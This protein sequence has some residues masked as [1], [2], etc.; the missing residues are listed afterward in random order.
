MH[1]GVV[2]ETVGLSAAALEQL[3]DVQVALRSALKVSSVEEIFRE[4]CLPASAGGFRNGKVARR[5]QTEGIPGDQGD[6]HKEDGSDGQ[7]RAAVAADELAGGVEEGV[8]ASL[9]R[10]AA[11]EVV[12]VEDEGVDRAIAP[13]GVGLEWCAGGEAAR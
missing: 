4:L 13:C 1:G 5:S 9:E 8:R 6:E 7:Q 11:K 3:I 10:T 2:A 12:D